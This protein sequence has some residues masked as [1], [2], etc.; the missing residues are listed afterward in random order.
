MSK[1][2]RLALP[3]AF[4]VLLAGCSGGDDSTSPT[5]TVTDVYGPE[6]GCAAGIPLDFQAALACI[7]EPPSG[8]DLTGTVT[9]R[10]FAMNTPANELTVE[11]QTADGVVL[12]SVIAPAPPGKTGRPARWEATLVIPPGIEEGPGRIVASVPAGEGEAVNSAAVD[13][14]LSPSV[15]P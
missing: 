10:G 6:F 14:N 13:V 5:A 2:T 1:I 9:V 4:A 11:L 12:Q 3:A 7:D 15:Q 8:S